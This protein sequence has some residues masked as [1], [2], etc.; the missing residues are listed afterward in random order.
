M[1]RNQL[2]RLIGETI[3]DIRQVKDHYTFY[4]DDGRELFSVP[5]DQLFDA[6]GFYFATQG[7]KEGVA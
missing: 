3:V 6:D 4:A 1:R 2:K 7:I 5:V